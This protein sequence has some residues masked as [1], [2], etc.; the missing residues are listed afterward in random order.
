MREEG[1]EGRRWSER[2]RGGKDGVVDCHV[3]IDAQV[4]D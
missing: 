3:F 4:A 2:G 1:E